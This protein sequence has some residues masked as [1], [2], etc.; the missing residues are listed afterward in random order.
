MPKQNLVLL[1]EDDP[2]TS[3]LYAALLNSEGMQVVQCGDGREARRQWRLLE[4]LPD[5]VV[6]DVRLPDGNGLDLCQELVNG[7]ASGMP[8]LVL[9]AHGDPRMPQRCRQAGA[10]AFLDKLVDLDSFL[11]TVRDILNK[12]QHAPDQS[13]N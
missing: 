13:G 5:L 2:D 1:V 4:R 7:N 10:C 6:V 8:V 11:E 3:A 9:S 12:S